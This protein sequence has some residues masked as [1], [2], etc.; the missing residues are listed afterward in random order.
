M[1][2]R[3]STTVHA[4]S[5]PPLTVHRP[6]FP[7][8]QP[9]DRSKL[10]S[11]RVIAR[12][13]D[14]VLV[15]APFLI[16]VLGLPVR[17]SLALLAVMLLYFFVCEAVW[18]RTLGKR[19][20]GLRVLMSDGRPA[21]PTAA[22]SRTVLRVIDDSPIGLLVYLASGKRRGRLGDLA[23]D[24]TVAWATPGLPR[25][26]FSPLHVVYPLVLLVVTAVLAVALTGVEHRHS[27]LA[28][29]DKVCAQQTKAHL[30]S[31]VR[32]LDGIVARKLADHRAMAAVSA[33]SGA[34]K[35]RAEILGLDA[36]VDQ[37]LVTAKRRAEASQDASRTLKA[38]TPRIAAARQKAATR[39]QHLGLRSCAGLSPA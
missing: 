34:G 38:E 5:P 9:E 31:P 18:G 4:P 25:A 32:D 11:R 17:L 27:Y 10:D 6:D 15:G 35:L 8:P 2:R 28:A 1:R 12:L 20:I 16:P 29:V 26:R 36:K 24:T 19:I 3:M 21:T 13:I 33:P 23:G 22:A 14:G 30:K 39:Y 7:A 37:A